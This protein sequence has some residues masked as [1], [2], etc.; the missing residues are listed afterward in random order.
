MRYDSDIFSYQFSIVASFVQHLAYYR[1]GKL[2]YDRL[3]VESPFWCATIDAHLKVATTQWCKVFG[4]NGCN[5]THWKRVATLDVKKEKASFRARLQK[6]GLQ[7]NHWEKYHKTMLAFRDKYVAH[8]EI[9]FLEPVPNFDTAL[10]VAYVYDEWVRDLIR[11]SIFAEFPLEEHFENWK[12]VSS[13]LIEAA[14][15]ATLGFAEST[16]NSIDYKQ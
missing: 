11:P 12:S 15:A 8:T 10:K 1:V 2:T 7:F 4:S 13:P 16:P 9:G 6:E 5:A 3:S 14:M